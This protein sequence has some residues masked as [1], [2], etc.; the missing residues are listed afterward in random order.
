M[1]LQELD[2]FFRDADK[3][4]TIA[5]RKLE[6][7]IGLPSRLPHDDSTQILRARYE[8]LF[9]EQRQYLRIALAN[10]N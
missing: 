1:P 4:A 6:A 8:R 10:P 5:L 2:V 7:V 9:A 3:N